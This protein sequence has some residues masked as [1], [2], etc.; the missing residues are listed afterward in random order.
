MSTESETAAETPALKGYMENSI[1]H[2]VPDRLVAPL[3]RKRDAVVRRVVKEGMEL[4]AALAAYR[5][6][7]AEACETFL[8]ESAAKY[9]TQLG[10]EKGNVTLSSYDGRLRLS[11]ATYDRMTFDER[12]QIAKTLIDECVKKW[13]RNT[14]KEPRAL[15]EAA[16]QVDKK[17]RLDPHRLLALRKLNIQDEQWC[18]A[19]TALSDSIQL[20][21]SKQYLRLQR[22]KGDGGYENIPLSL[23][24]V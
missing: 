4:S 21:R 18:K 22:R 12:L 9:D 20:S 24:S 11:L 6:S 23:A 2:L 1:G 19:M 7:A 3:D 15:I 10:G 13:T 8:Q 16:F 17:G 5:R 14:R